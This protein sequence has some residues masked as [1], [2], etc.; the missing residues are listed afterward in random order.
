MI[1]AQAAAAI[2]LVPIRN[3]R[4]SYAAK[5]L[6]GALLVTQA[7]WLFFFAS[8]AGATLGLFALFVLA[9]L[10]LTTKPLRRAGP[11]LAAGAA[12]SLFIFALV[13]DPSLLALA[14]FWLFASLAILLPR[15]GGFDDGWRWAIRLAA[16]FCR[17][18]LAPIGDGRRLRA[19]GRRRGG[20]R[21]AARLPSLW[22][23]L[24]GTGLFIG[25]FAAANP[26]IANAFARLDIAS[27]VAAISFARI[28]FW[29]LIAA[30][31]WPFFRPRLL[32]L[33]PAAAGN[34]DRLL[35]GFSL[36]S[37]TLSLLAFNAV[38]ALQNGLDLA[39]LWS[40]APL[41][42][43]MTL[44]EYAHRGAYPLIATAL[45]AGLFVL[46]TLRPGSAMA[47]QPAIRRLVY[48]WIAQNVLL[49]A[50]T[51]L[52]TVDYVEAY[53]LT[54]LRI[55]ALIW[56]ALVAIG[57]V[58]I[59]WRIARGRSGAWLINANMIAALLV[60]TACSFVDLG[61]MAAGWNVRHARETGGAG[62]ALDLCYLNQLDASALLP[63]VGLE[64]RPLP[65]LLRERAAWTRN[66][67]MD[68]LEQSQRDWHAWTWRG[69]RR[70]A[71]AQ[72]LVAARHLPRFTAGRREC[73]GAPVPPPPAPPLTATPER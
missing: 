15:A 13:E 68:R 27:L 10:F 42:A 60:L 31:L 28:G 64:S 17:S 73:D 44:A 36:A 21:I 16:H 63:L 65:P 26:V 50:S 7:D 25:L 54:R 29:L 59:C 24:I 55:A 53:S 23:P 33:A 41:P 57:L 14:L 39:F 34:P 35:P 6:A 67:I 71:E 52:R 45:L 48:A 2:P 61:S 30:L 9:A 18:L 69:A 1:M 8:D 70:L 43:G 72:S 4:F 11:P 58:L 38:F 47:G 3:R 37:V 66:L 22:L 40:G 32:L 12:A 62:S 19:A 56:M 20:F 5:I 49:V 51:I 46:V